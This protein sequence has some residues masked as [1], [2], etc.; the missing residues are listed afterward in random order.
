MGLHVAVAK[1][2]IPLSEMAFSDCR[3]DIS[4]SGR[5]PNAFYDRT[6]LLARP[7]LIV[8]EALLARKVRPT[9][10]LTLGR[11]RDGSVTNGN[12]EAGLED[13]GVPSWRERRS[14]WGSCA[15]QTKKKRG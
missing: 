13:F 5:A 9:V 7:D 8:I 15:S 1:N 11:C 4:L 12:H 14:C 2:H 10:N 3:Q 6:G